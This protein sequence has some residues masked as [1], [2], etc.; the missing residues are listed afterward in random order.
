MGKFHWKKFG[1]NLGRAISKIKGSD[2]KKGIRKGVGVT[3]NAAEVLQ[4][5]KIGAEQSASNFQAAMDD[6]QIVK[7]NDQSLASRPGGMGSGG[8]YS[9]SSSSSSGGYNSSGYTRSSAPPRN[10]R[11]STVG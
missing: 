10:S 8:S 2:I 4:A 11:V 1:K 6:G 9:S 7:Y 3:Q 5:A